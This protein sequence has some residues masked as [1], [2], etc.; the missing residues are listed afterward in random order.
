MDRFGVDVL[1]DGLRDVGLR[2][3]RQEGGAIGV[4]QAVVVRDGARGLHEARI[5]TRLGPLAIAFAICAICLSAKPCAVCQRLKRSLS[6]RISVSISRSLAEVLSLT[7]AEKSRSNGQHGP[8]ADIFE[9]E[10]FFLLP[11]HDHAIRHGLSLLFQRQLFAIAAEQAKLDGDGN[12]LS[13]R[14][15][16]DRRIGLAKGETGGL[17]LANR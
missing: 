11:K 5:G 8:L 17:G 6:E 15:L 10:D 9:G 12:G 3:K 13:F 16:S 4:L 14:A 2:G 1:P 7:G